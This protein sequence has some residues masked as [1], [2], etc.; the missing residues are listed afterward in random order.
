MS[1]DHEGLRSLLREELE[2]AVGHLRSDVQKLQGDV[3]NALQRISQLERSGSTLPSPRSAL[4]Q[5]SVASSDLPR[6]SSRGSV[7]FFSRGESE[8]A[9]VSSDTFILNTFPAKTSREDIK[10]WLSP[11]V[12]KYVGDVEFTV[13]SPSRYST[14]VF[15]QFASAMRAKAFS[16]AW[17]KEVQS[18]PVQGQEPTRIYLNWKLSPARAKEEFLIR[19]FFVYAR[20]VL[21]VPADQLEKERATRTIYV[22]KVL[23]AR[24][25]NGSLALTQAGKTYANLEKFQAWLTA[26][27]DKQQSL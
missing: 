3:A 19:Q 24:I 10:N 21:R 14:R 1:L 11:I 8:K 20:D 16:I 22:D 18:Y 7:G 6:K 13:S 12:Q 25:E 9:P 23:I 26:K 5:P 15:V 27:E 2:N 4:R 17:R